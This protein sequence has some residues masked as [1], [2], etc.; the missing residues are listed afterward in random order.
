VTGLLKLDPDR[1]IVLYAV[2]VGRALADDRVQRRFPA[3]GATAFRQ[4]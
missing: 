4:F 2:A 1:E 3:E